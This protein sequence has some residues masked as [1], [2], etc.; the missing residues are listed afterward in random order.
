MIP[1]TDPGAI[2]LMTSDRKKV[3]E[4]TILYYANFP[5]HPK[6]IGNDEGDL[7]RYL[8]IENISIVY[9]RMTTFATIEALMD[10]HLEANEWCLHGIKDLDNPG[11]TMAEA[12]ALLTLRTKQVS[13]RQRVLND[14]LGYYQAICR[15][16]TMGFMGPIER[17]LL[18]QENV[19]APD[20]E[21]RFLLTTFETLHALMEQ[22]SKSDDLV[23][24]SV[25][26]LDTD[27]S[28]PHIMKGIEQ[29]I[30]ARRNPSEEDTAFSEA[31]EDRLEQI[32]RRLLGY[33]VSKANIQ[34]RDLGAPFKVLPDEQSAIKKFENQ[35]AEDIVFL[36]GQLN[37]LV[38][39]GEG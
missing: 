36:L 37:R 29:E 18:V 16:K 3:L 34:N 31:D 11:A 2:I 14:Y 21:G 7:Q 6:I 13:D 10:F 30:S 23:T 33:L 20:V 1:P 25:V 38:I 39:L 8:L 12:H 32:E 22:A 15:Q 28:L 27:K 5:S 17:Y 24:I 35:A 19:E 9:Y 4:D 26:D